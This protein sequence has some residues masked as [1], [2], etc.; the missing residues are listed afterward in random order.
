MSTSGSEP[1]TEAFLEIEKAYANW[2]GALMRFAY[3]LCGNRDD[4]EDLVV[5]TFTHAF[6]NRDRLRNRDLMRQWLYGIAVNRYRMSRRKQKNRPE[7]LSEDLPVHGADPLD[8][9]ALHQAIADLPL[10]QREAFLLVKSEGLTYR[11]AAEALGKP[12]GTVLSDVHQSVKALQ[13]AILGEDSGYEA[14]KTRLC[15]A[16]P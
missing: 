1:N 13:K 16:E 4:A 2:G 5:E 8:Q 10:S 14:A 3:R 12:L 6:R 15:E 7:P 9:V 11:E